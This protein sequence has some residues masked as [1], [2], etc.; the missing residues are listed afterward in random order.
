MTTVTFKELDFD[1]RRSNKRRTVGITVERDGQ[2]ILCA[3][4]EVPL[5]TLEQIV[6]SRRFWI[7]SKLLKKEALN[8]PVV[9][10]EYVSGEGFYYLGRS[11]RL[12]LVDEVQSQVPLRLHQG[13]FYLHRSLAAK[14]RELFIA[15]YRAHLKPY[16]EAKVTDL[17]PRVGAN[18]NSIQ[19][20][21]L[22]NRWGSCT[23][24]GNL[25]FHWRVAMLPHQAIEYAIVHEMIHLL[26][27]Q[28]DRNF[29]EL[30]ER[31]LPDYLERKNWL[32]SNGVSYNL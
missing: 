6:E 25:Y 12:K 19:V 16:L 3:P 15:L 13:R 5:E 28:H 18:P 4:P 11:Y 23:P 8:P 20:R 30:V 24:R 21:E 1:L 26:E 29:W 14:G 9:A 32:A 22:G 31:L 2:L 17:I 10:K 27:P 7:Y